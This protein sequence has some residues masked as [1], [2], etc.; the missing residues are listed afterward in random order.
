MVSAAGARS[1]IGRAP[2]GADALAARRR[3]PG[4]RPAALALVA[5]GGGAARRSRS[6]FLA[7]ELSHPRPWLRL[8]PGAGRR[9]AGRTAP[10][11]QGGRAGRGSVLAGPRPEQAGH[12][13]LARRHVPPHRHRVPPRPSGHRHQRLRRRDPDRRGRR[14]ARRDPPAL[15]AGPHA[16]RLRARR[17]ARDPHRR[18]EVIVREVQVRPR[19]FAQ[20]ARGRHDVPR[21]GDARAGA[22]PFQLH[23]RRLP[24]PPARGHH[25]RAGERAC[26]KAA[27]GCPTARRSRS[28]GG[29]AGFDFP[30]R[31]IIRGRWEIE[32][33]RLQR[34]RF[35]RRCS[36]GRPI[37]GLAAAARRLRPGPVRWPQ[38]IADVAAAGQPP[39]HGGAAGEVERIAGARALSGL[40]AQPTRHRV[41]QRYRAGEPGPGARARLRRRDRRSAAGSSSGRRSA[42][43]PRTTGSPAASR[44][45]PGPAPPSLARRRAAHPRLQ[46]LPVISPG[47]QLAAR[48]GG[49]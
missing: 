26:S 45:W 41:T 11:G 47:A 48:A 1:A 6:R 40:P 39:G 13:R 8:L 43:A 46:R 29:P 7:R 4:T 2:A 9:G 17:L 3:R 23:P 32:R 12:P 15:P 28:G 42:T 19:S 49:G 44:C 31:G 18:G 33:L 24:R 36:P 21:R 37:G 10:A 25:H 35:R 30:A 38:A 14:G 20:P 5:T 22:L 16:L 27:G 34:R